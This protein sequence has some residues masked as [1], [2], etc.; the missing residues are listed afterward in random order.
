MNKTS[1]KTSNYT[2]NFEKDE[3]HYLERHPISFITKIVQ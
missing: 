1:F 3:H 2:L